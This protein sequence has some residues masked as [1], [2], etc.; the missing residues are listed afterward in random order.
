[1]GR[2]R[3]MSNDSALQQL[4]D[5]KCDVLLHFTVLFLFVIFLPLLC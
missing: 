2:N 1:M 4:P 5:L 3:N